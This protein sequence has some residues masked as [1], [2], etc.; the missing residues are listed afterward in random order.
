M[1]HISGCQNSFQGQV[2]LVRVQAARSR[3]LLHVISSERGGGSPWPKGREG[4]GSFHNGNND[5]CSR[6]IFHNQNINADSVWDH[7]MPIQISLQTGTVMT[8]MTPDGSLRSPKQRGLKWLQHWTSTSWCARGPVQSAS[9]S[10]HTEC[11]LVREWSLD[12][13]A[14][15]EVLYLTFSLSFFT[16]MMFTSASS[17]AAHISFSI[18][19]STCKWMHVWVSLSLGRNLDLQLLETRDLTE[20]GTHLFIYDSCCAQRPESC[21]YFTTQISQNHLES[22][23]LASNQTFYFPRGFINPLRHST[24]W[25]RITCSVVGWLQFCF[26]VMTTRFLI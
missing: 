14:N 26:A 18:E 4:G 5:T 23:S 17:N 19:L 9:G 3:A 12:P 6:L 7:M 20:Q 1:R 22:E 10:G 16:N 25:G 8:A 11:T 21:C 13:K 2:R 24:F 15:T